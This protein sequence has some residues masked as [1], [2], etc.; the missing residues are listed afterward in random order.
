MSAELNCDYI[1]AYFLDKLLKISLRFITCLISD[2]TARDL[3][4]FFDEICDV[5]LKAYDS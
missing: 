4:D 2:E 5:C 3:R 1:K